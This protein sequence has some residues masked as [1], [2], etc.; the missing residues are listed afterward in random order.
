MTA[1]LVVVTNDD[2]V[3]SPGI[4]AMASALAQDFDVIVAAPADDK[5]GSGTGVGGIDFDKG[6]ALQPVAVD[7]V[8]AAYSVDG[9]PGLAVTA[10]ALG[11]FGRIPD[12]VASGINAGINTGHSI[13]HSGTVGA[14]LTARTFKIKG[15]AVSLSQSDP[16]HWETAARYA[17]SVAHWLLE[18]AKTPYVMNVNV[19]ALPL[20]EVKG[21][22]WA[23]LAEFGYFRVATADIPGERLQFEVG[24]TR[25][26]SDP[27]SDTILCS[28]GYVTLTPLNTVEPAPFPEVSAD[29][30]A[31][32]LAT[33]SEAASRGNRPQ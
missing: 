10:A 23:D 14:A 28:D 13:I 8:Q 7:G 17:R 20:E 27:G 31:G 18:K 1:P 19:P 15:L 6:V 11:A 25:A 30:L 5:S 2:G 12:L 22:H 26:D 29:S 4:Q 33:V 21:M 9:P 32:D 24:P 16:W 3:D